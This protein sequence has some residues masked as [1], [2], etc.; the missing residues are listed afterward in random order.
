MWTGATLAKEQSLA[1]VG[2]LR[3]RIEF[4]ELAF[5]KEKLMNLDYIP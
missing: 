4:I 5:Q 1:N 2:F 3:M